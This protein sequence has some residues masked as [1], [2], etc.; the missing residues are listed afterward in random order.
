[1]VAAVVA[2]I[3]AA[4]VWAASSVVT[5]HSEPWDAEGGYYLGGLL[6]AGLVAGAIAP[7]A[8]WAHYCGAIAGQLVYMIL[9]QRVGPLIGDGVLFLAL[10]ALALVGGSLIGA[11]MRLALR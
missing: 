10:Y 9:F 1:M 3:A 8:P 6:L 5:G 4:I 7:Y 2:A 11:R